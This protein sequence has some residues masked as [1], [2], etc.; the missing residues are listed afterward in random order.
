MYADKSLKENLQS[1]SD[2]VTCLHFHFTKQCT[3]F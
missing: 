3:K 1:V 2:G